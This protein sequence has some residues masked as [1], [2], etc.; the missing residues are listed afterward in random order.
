MKKLIIALIIL[1]VAGSAFAG[2]QYAKESNEMGDINLEM[3]FTYDSDPDYDALLGIGEEDQVG[4][5]LVLYVKSE[6]FLSGNKIDIKIDDGKIIS[7]PAIQ[8]KQIFI[9]PITPALVHTLKTGKAMKIRFETQADIH[10]VDFSL[11]GSATAINK[12]KGGE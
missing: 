12:L 11:D 4:I 6:Q 7:L 9:A 8:H 2:W 3:A 10:T 1:M 5:V